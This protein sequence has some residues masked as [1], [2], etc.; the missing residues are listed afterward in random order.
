MKLALALLRLSVMT[1]KELHQL[2]VMNRA[3][4][5]AA[6][7][8][9]LRY[10][11]DSVRGIRRLGVAKNFRYYGPTGSR[12]RDP[13]QLRRINSLVIP[14]AWSDVWISPFPNSHL[15]ATG[16]DARSRKQY[17]YHPHWRALRDQTKYSR[18]LLVGGILPKLRAR[19]A[20]DLALPG[21][22]R[23]KVIATVVKLLETTLI[24]IG[25]IE[26][27]RENNSFGL[28][29]LCNLHVKVTGAT[30]RF[31]FRG[32]SKIDRDI[33]FS[34]KK[35]AQIVRRCQ[36]L[37]GQ[38]L[39]Q[40]IDTDENLRR[41]SSSDINDY[42][43]K[44]AGF[45]LTAKDFRTWAGTVLAVRELG[46]AEPANS[47]AQLKRNI[48]RAVEVVAKRLGN[49]RTVCQKCYIHPSI[50]KAYADG[51]LANVV[52]RQAR[53]AGDKSSTSMIAAESTVMFILS[54]SP[55]TEVARKVA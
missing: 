36:E 8:F 18:M 22:P 39:F 28:T 50:M 25:N 51:S 55:M 19:V 7:T 23:A 42:L 41:V 29:T 20:K 5:Q 14:P 49:T 54:Q 31:R 26:Y 3:P 11:T 52:A 1:R 2:T 38:E 24:R 45:D 40:Y 30:I 12:L 43:R 9:G 10:I 15:Q 33:D 16:R 27:A 17:R 13:S 46:N 53:R 4:N 32:K 48:V 21:L 37:P 35:L 44:A 6:K 47:K 34:N